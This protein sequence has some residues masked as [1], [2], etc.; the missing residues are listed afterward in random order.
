[1]KLMRVKETNEK[2]ARHGNFGNIIDLTV[3][4]FNL[5]NKMFIPYN[6]LKNW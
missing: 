1:M 3:F 2:D 6:T 5:N 4:Q